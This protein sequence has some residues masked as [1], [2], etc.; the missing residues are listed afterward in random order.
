MF[1]G[2][3]TSIICT[4]PIYSFLVCVLSGTKNPR[5]KD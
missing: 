4:P 5:E 2:K 1:V 3:T